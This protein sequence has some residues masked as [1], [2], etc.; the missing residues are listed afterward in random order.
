MPVD[1]FDLSDSIFLL[2]SDSINHWI[3]TRSWREESDKMYPRG[4]EEMSNNS[5]VVRERGS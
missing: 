4:I 3:A 1:M 2:P 5:V